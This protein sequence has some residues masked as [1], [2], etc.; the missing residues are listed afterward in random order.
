[1]ATKNRRDK[2]AEY[3]GKWYKCVAAYLWA[4]FIF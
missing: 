3:V 2:G 4:S 1:M